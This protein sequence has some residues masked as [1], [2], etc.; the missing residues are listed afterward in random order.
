[1]ECKDL[2][3]YNPTLN[4]VSVEKKDFNVKATRVDKKLSHLNKKWIQT[5]RA[6]GIKALYFI[7]KRFFNEDCRVLDQD[8][9]WVLIIKGGKFKSKE[10]KDRILD[11]ELQFLYAFTFLEKIRFPSLALI[12]L[13]SDRFMTIG[14]LISSLKVDL[15]T[16]KNGGLSCICRERE[17]SGNKVAS[18][19][20]E[21]FY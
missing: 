2:Q 12:N 16:K 15:T 8:Q 5:R 3:A 13:S 4:Y 6:L 18:K 20:V 1:M 17:Y 10:L 21:Y 11:I 9:D 14:Q 7:L 19:H